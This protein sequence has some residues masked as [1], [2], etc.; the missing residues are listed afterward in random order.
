[1]PVSS[2]K[3]TF[4]QFKDSQKNLADVLLSGELSEQEYMKWAAEN[5]QIPYLSDD[6]FN[7]TNNYQLITENP[8]SAW[9][10]YFFPIHEWQG[11]LYVGCIEPKELQI[12]KKVCFVLCSPKQLL[13]LWIKMEKPDLLIPIPRA[14]EEKIAPVS[15]RSKPKLDELNISS[16]QKPAQTDRLAISHDAA[17]GLDFSSLDAEIKEES[18]P[19]TEEVKT[20][21][22]EGISS[23]PKTVA[24]KDPLPAE[25]IISCTSNA[26]SPSLEITLPGESPP[27]EEITA[28]ILV[29]VT[30][31]NIS[32]QHGVHASVDTGKE[33]TPALSSENDVLAEKLSL[34][35][36]EEEPSPL[37]Q[38]EST[39]PFQEPIV[40]PTA[41]THGLSVNP[42][43][44]P[45]NYDIPEITNVVK[46][47]KVTINDTSFTSTKTIMPF[48]ERTTQF[49]FIRTV[50]SEQVILEAKAKVQENTDP[51]DALMSAFRI[52]RDYY[53][54]LMWIVRD[55]KGYAY[56]IACNTEWEF[57]EDAWNFPIDFKTPN[58]FRIA[59]FTQKPFHGV[60]SKNPASD[61]FFQH[62]CHGSE[63]DIF[64]VVPVKIHGKVFGYFVGCDKGTH[65]HP[66]HSLEIMESVCNELIEVFI[67]IHREL[68]KAS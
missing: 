31:T 37:P 52:L 22:T 56:P 16:E 13:S 47:P 43:F 17:I 60:V 41:K 65:Y 46:T 39:T 42:N 59:K 40:I 36:Q 68:A 21:H 27:D 3:E 67:R 1:M 62:W 2:W 23:P 61:L 49:T 32:L 48:P 45:T 50:Y 15:P 24:A 10:T 66:Q 63:P 18:P 14:M 20:Q 30:E 4:S 11:M 64:T 29:P 38:M 6:F 5:Y 53:K 35:V 58:P 34:D 25:K 55:Q 8:N 54:R 57:T 33:L 28:D 19:Q 44:T 7:Q 26:T 9:D 51:Q 12:N